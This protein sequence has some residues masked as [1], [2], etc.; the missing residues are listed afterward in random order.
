MDANQAMSQLS[1]TADRM[2]EAAKN[3]LSDVSHKVRER[4]LAAATTTDAYVHQ[5]AWSS[6]ALAALVGVAVGL[7]IRR[8]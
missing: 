8:S 5:Y 7:L 4:S 6:V 1:E 2:S 3:K